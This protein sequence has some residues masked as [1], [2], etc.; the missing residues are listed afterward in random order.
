LQGDGF[1]SAGGTS[2]EPVAVGLVG[3]QKALGGGFARSALG[4]EDALWGVRCH[5]VPEKY[6]LMGSVT[7]F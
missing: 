3:A 6:N 4:N 1:A 7:N 5:G 2:D